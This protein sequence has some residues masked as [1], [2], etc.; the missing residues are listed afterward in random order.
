MN[1]EINKKKGKSKIFL[2]ICILWVK[3]CKKI[4]RSDNN[5][6]YLHG[7][8]SNRHRG[9]VISSIQVNGVQVEGVSNVRKVVFSHFAYHFKSANVQRPWP[10]NLNFQTQSYGGG[11]DVDHAFLFASLIKK[12]FHTVKSAYRYAMENLIDNEEYQIS[13]SISIS[14]DWMRMWNLQLSQRV[15]VFLWRV[16]KGFLPARIRHQD[17]EVLCTDCCPRWENSY[18]NDWHLFIDSEAAKQVWQVAG[19]W[20]LI[21]DATASVRTL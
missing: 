4:K 12:C 15:K 19:L 18:E 10:T 16:F 11:G 2:Y 13:I 20:E 9:N 21:R 5:S 3:S 7:T 17:R 1:K 6:K 8:M 14:G